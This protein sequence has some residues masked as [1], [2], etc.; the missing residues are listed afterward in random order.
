MFVRIGV[1]AMALAASAPAAAQSDLERGFDG[2]L[3][4]CEN[5]VLDPATWANGLEAFASRLGLGDKAGWVAS[6]N[7]SALPPPQMRTANHYLRIN[8]TP[9]AGFILVVSDRAPFCHITG[10]GGADLQPI[11]ES[12]LAS[13]TFKGRWER[14]KI[15]SRGDM[16]SATFRNRTD[17]KLE[18]VVSYAAKAGERLE[19]VQ[20]LA[21]AQYRLGG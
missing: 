14:V 13:E 17:P 18:M 4:A 6:V 11:V 3:R 16:V 20:V 2:A 7:E 8:S 5:W 9:N 15:Q 12:E 1:A 19:R 10:G 21:S